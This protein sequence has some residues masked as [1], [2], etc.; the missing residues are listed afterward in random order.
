MEET[1]TNVLHVL[2]QDTSSKESAYLN[3]LQ[4]TIYSTAAA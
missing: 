3:A 2:L 1:A 4:A